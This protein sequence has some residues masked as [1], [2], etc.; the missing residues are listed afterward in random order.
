MGKETQILIYIFNFFRFSCVVQSKIRVEIHNTN[1]KKEKRINSLD[2]FC[3]D[4][5]GCEDGIK[6]LFL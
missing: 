6:I 3:F 5:C 2:D 4:N 1:N